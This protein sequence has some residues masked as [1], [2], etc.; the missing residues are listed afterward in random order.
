M[1]RAATRASRRGVNF[2]F[3]RI[4]RSDLSS[5]AQDV[6]GWTFADI[7]EAHEALDAYEELTAIAS[8]EA[9]PKS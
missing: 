8:D 2:I 4:A 1:E 3:Y 7:F 6:R 5:G 9:R